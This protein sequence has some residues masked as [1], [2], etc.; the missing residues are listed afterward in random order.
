MAWVLWAMAVAG[1]ATL[2]WFDHLLRQAGRPELTGA[3]GAVLVVLAAGVGLALLPLAAGSLWLRP[4]DGR[5]V[6][7][8]GG[9]RVG[10]VRRHR[11]AGRA[12]WPGGRRRPGSGSRA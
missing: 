11:P 9:R 4:S 6:R 5:P 2:P 3:T 12:R 1:V 8:R 7:V 10:R